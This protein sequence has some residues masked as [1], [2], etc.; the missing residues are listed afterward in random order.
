MIPV[1]ALHESNG[2]HYVNIM[3]YGQKVKRTIEIGL[4]SDMYVEVKSGL[5]A[6]ESVV[7]K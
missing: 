3:Q 4:K 6:G 1:G 2:V 5:E 7:T